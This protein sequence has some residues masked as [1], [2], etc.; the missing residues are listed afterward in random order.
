MRKFTTFIITIEDISTTDGTC[1]GK[2]E[3]RCKYIVS[4]LKKLLKLYE[5]YNISIYSCSAKDTVYSGTF[6]YGAIELYTLMKH[7]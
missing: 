7:K 4:E 6:D 5:G 2:W 1:Y 3:F